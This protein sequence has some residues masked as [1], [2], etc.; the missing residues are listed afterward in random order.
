M[1]ISNKQKAM[2]NKPYKIR[3]RKGDTVIIRSGKFK[4]RSGQ[5]L[6]TQPADNTL[7]IEGLNVVK[8]HLKPI[9]GR[10]QSGVVEITK[11]LPVSKVGILDPQAKRAGRVGYKLTKD[12]TKLR[13]Y[14]SS[15]KEIRS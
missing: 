1:T 10:R 15:G 8:R 9:Q 6:A 3:L 11:P 4:G 14:K 7:T 12:G 2:N 13:I 5:V